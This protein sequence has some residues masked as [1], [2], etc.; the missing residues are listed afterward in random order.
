MNVISAR[1]EITQLEYSKYDAAKYDLILIDIGN[2][3]K[4][5]R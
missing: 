3:K 4:T 1:Y 5:K 2:L